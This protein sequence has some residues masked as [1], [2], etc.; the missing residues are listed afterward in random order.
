MNERELYIK[1]TLYE[2]LCIKP[3]DNLTIEKLVKFEELFLNYNLHTNLMSKND[4]HII[5]EK[6][7]YDSLSF[8]KFMKKYLFYNKIAK[9]MDIGT[10]GG[11]P[12]I[13]IGICF[14]NLDILVIDSFFKKITF[15]NEVI[16]ELHIINLKTKCQ[17][18]E[19]LPYD[20]KNK[21]DIVTSRA[22]APL[23]ILL[24]YGMPF[25]KKDSY[26]VAYKGKHIKD[27]IFLAKNALKKLNS[28]IVDI[29][30]YEL[31]LEIDYV[32][33]LVI[34]KKLKETSSQYPRSYTNIKNNPL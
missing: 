27:E 30:N 31:P 17:R 25:V 2:G 7:I 21:Y 10:G 24:E 5:F 23:N 26:F 9:V 3:P 1:N 18:I 6:H 14:D 33:N 20:L 15:I 29:I 22:L 13:P 32:R 16:N 12:A 28:Q 8:V 34:I 19:K 4:L 11:F